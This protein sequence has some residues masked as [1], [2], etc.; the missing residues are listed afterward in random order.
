[1]ETAMNNSLNDSADELNH[2]SST[3]VVDLENKLQKQWT[4][5]MKSNYVEYKK[6]TEWILI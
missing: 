6:M 3:D 4:H 2:T 5:N 1:M